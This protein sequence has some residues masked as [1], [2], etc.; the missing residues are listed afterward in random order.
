MIWI[1]LILASAVTLGIYDV[2]RKHAVNENGVMP[3][4]FLATTAGTVSVLI[5]QACGGILLTTLAVSWLTWW[6]LVLKALIV[7]SSWICAY[8]GMRS[9]P[10]SIAAP[11][12]GSQ[13][14]WTLAGALLV[15]AERPHPLQW[16]GIGATIL[17]YYLFSVI[18][19]R[20]GIVFHRNKGIALILAATL[21]G[22]AS[23]LYDK[24]LLQL[25]KIPPETVQV[26]FQIN[27][28]LLIGGTWLVQSLAGLRKTKFVWKWSIPAVGILLV[29]SDWLYFTALHQP[30]A[31]ISILSP[32]RRSNA[33][34]SFIV[35]GMVFRDKN[36][37][38]KSWAL[39]L[40]ML[41]VLILC[42]PPEAAARWMERWR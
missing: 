1:V 8:Y 7:T 15:Y 40:I 27:L 37:K 19:K 6:Q 33:V 35:G 14:V 25:P 34:L 22:A 5:F 2:A 20:E 26:W 41:G 18:G 36:R 17:G 29:I 23:G 31:L 13:P 42:I 24:Y 39:A 10:I 12:R 21:L 9:L 30:D 28:S 11:I 3:V 16:A 32:I 4:L 38:A